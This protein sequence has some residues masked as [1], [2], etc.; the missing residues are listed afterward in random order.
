MIMRNQE[1]L[2]HTLW[3]HC[4]GFYKEQHNGPAAIR[5]HVGVDR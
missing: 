4:G 3:K 2:L 5:V 1:L